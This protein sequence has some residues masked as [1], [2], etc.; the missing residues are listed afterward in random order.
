MKMR[1][2]NTVL[3]VVKAERPAAAKLAETIKLWLTE[4][5]YT[6][7]LVKSACED[8]AYNRNDLCL[9]VVL[10]GD[11]TMLGAARRL[12]GRSVPILGINFGRVGFLTPVPPNGWREA[13]ECVLSGKGVIQ[14]NIALEWKIMRGRELFGGV[15]VNDIVLC[16]GAISRV[17]TLEMF[18]NDQQICHLRA[19]GLVVSSPLGSSAYTVSAGGPLL[20]PSVEAFVLTP[21]CPFLSSV[22]PMV[23]PGSTAFRAVLHEGALETNLTADGQEI[24]PLKANDEVLI[25]AVPRGV[26]LA[27]TQRDSYFE[28]LAQR[29]FLGN[30]SLCSTL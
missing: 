7:I 20:Y 28:R 26:L 14:E 19:D 6:S 27:Y 5:N 17:N 8:S 9:S 1:E 15:A 22:P 4:H 23:F 10:G 29:G 25:R 16:R 21:I 24:Y 18:A 12:I 2:K 11:G 30:R 3:I 13:L